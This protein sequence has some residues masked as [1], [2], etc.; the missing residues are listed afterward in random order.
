MYAIGA[1]SP[2]TALSA[3]L[4][5]THAE[6]ASFEVSLM[7]WERAAFYL[8]KKVEWEHEIGAEL[9]LA[10][11]TLASGYD[12]DMYSVGITGNSHIPRPIGYIL[13][14]RQRH[15]YAIVT[16]SEAPCGL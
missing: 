14:H 4:A 13:V 16:R 3:L 2:A 15:T 11:Q 6:G 9:A 8:S 1:E 12:A 7:H 5:A 10:I